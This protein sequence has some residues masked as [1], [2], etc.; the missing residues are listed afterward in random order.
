MTSGTPI[1]EKTR[2][3]LKSPVGRVVLDTDVSRELINPFFQGERLTVTVG[4]R[5]TE[6]LQELGFSPDLEVVDS[7]EKRKTRKVPPLSEFEHRRV[8]L[9]TNPPGEISA[10]SLEKISACLDL[11]SDGHNKLR[12]EVR[13]EEDLLALPVIAFFPKDT[14]TFY[15]QPN[16]GLVIVNS[17][18]SR[19]KS[20]KILSEM[21]ISSLPSLG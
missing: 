14:V 10:D 16:V 6:R 19:E 11:L 20:L 18:E 12:L 7:L 13:G 17:P 2:D 5:T 1:S 8:L 9:A 3:E 21:G 4:D 15:G